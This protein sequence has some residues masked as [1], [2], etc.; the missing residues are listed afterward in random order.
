MRS[1]YQTL[2][3]HELAAILAANPVT[4][5]DLEIIRDK[6]DPRRFYGVYLR[7]RR[8]VRY[9]ARVLKYLELGGKFLTIREAA[10]AVVAWYKHKFGERWARAFRNRSRSVWRTVE[11]WKRVVWSTRPD[12]KDCIGWRAEV[13]IRGTPQVVSL[14]DAGLVNERRATQRYLFPSRDEAKRAARAALANI[15]EK[16]KATVPALLLWRGA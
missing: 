9:R 3:P 1:T 10:S 15:I 6:R 8:N 5:A 14:A 13:F 16:R 2:P 12:Q 4:V 11:V 7:E